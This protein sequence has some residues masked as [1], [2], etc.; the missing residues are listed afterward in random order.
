MDSSLIIAEVGPNHNGSFD[1][2]E[3]ITC[4]LAAINIDAVKYQLANPFEV[5]SKDSFKA[6]YQKKNDDKKSAIE[7]SM[8]YQLNFQEHEKLSQLCHKLNIEYMCTGFD[9]G[10]LTFL[11]EELN[12]KRFKIPSGEIFSIDLLEYIRRFDKPIILSTGM[13]NLKEIKETINFLNSNQKKDITVLHCISNYPTPIKHVNMRFMKTIQKDCGVKVGFSDHTLGN[14]SSITAIAM[15]AKIIEKHVTLDKSL[16]GPDHKAS[17]T[18]PEFEDLVK[19]IRDVEIIKG[20]YSKKFTEEE[21]KIHNVARKS[22]VSRKKLEIGQIIL[23]E[24]ICFKRPGTGVSPLDLDLIL[25]KK[26]KNNI[27]ADKV[28][29]LKDLQ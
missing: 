24:D 7:M 5:Y 9:I 29:H 20:N 25:G 23:R 17:A 19:Q 27:A 22:V 14:L 13:A 12:V 3:K 4:E 26:V 10:S 21:R 16:P 1:L 6:D 2:A 18:I 15:G 28:I 11:N 8:S